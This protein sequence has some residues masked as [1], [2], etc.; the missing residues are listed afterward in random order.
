MFGSIGMTELI[1]ILVVA[2][3]VIGP[4]RL[5]EVAK[6]IGR[7]LRDF[8]RATSDLQDSISLDETDYEPHPA[9]RTEESESDKSAAVS[10]PND[11]AAPDSPASGTGGTAASADEAA[12]AEEATP[13]DVS[14]KG[15]PAS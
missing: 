6:S 5:P 9:S 15:K 2:L 13:S 12:S 8:K 1:V 4:K 14:E 3:I 11:T 10:P 7:S